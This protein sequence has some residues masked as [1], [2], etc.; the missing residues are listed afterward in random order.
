M[1]TRFLLNISV[2]VTSAVSGK[3]DILV[4]GSAPGYR[5]VSQ[6]QERGSVDVMSLTDLINDEIMHPEQEE[7]EA[8][9]LQ[10]M[11]GSSGSR[12]LVAGRKS[13]NRKRR[14]SRSPMVITEFSTGYNGNGL[15]QYMLGNGEAYEVQA[16]GSAPAPEDPPVDRRR[17]RRRQW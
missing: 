1:S 5:K 13:G 7:E 6:A 4:V 17:R 9:L 11:A 15:G 14:R 12:D 2:Q 16:L 8:P 3:T 10:G